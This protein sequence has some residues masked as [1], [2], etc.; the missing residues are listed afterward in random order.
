MMTTIM[1]GTMVSSASL[2]P[3]DSDKDDGNGKV[4]AIREL[5]SKPTIDLW[6]L[7]ELAL[8]EGGLVNGALLAVGRSRSLI[9][10]AKLISSF[11]FPHR[12][13]SLF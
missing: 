11:L 13:F 3:D 10:E 5:L 4:E 2:S 9:R 7:R 8:T 12:I 1:T 6:K